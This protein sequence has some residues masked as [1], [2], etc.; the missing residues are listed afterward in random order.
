MWSVNVTYYFS[1][2]QKKVCF[3]LAIFDNGLVFFLYIFF[4]YKYVNN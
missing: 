2:L 4:F 3:F 1:E